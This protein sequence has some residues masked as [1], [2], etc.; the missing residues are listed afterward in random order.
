MNALIQDLQNQAYSTKCTRL[1]QEFI[2]L[3]GQPPCGEYYAEQAHT[4]KIYTCL[5]DIYACAHKIYTKVYPSDFDKF[6]RSFPKDQ[7]RLPPAVEYAQSAYRLMNF[8][9]L[10]IPKL[11]GMTFGDQKELYTD[12]RKKSEPENQIPPVFRMNM[13]I[14]VYL[15]ASK[16]LICGPLWK[17]FWTIFQFRC[18]KVFRFRTGQMIMS[19]NDDQLLKLIRVIQMEWKSIP[20]SLEFCTTFQVIEMAFAL[21]ISRVGDDS[22]YTI[23]CYRIESGEPGVYSFNETCIAMYSTILYGIKRR[24]CIY[25]TNLSR[26]TV[27]EYVSPESLRLSKL[28]MGVDPHSIGDGDDDDHGND[29][30]SCATESEKEGNKTNGGGVHRDTIID[31][32]PSKYE[33]QFLYERIKQGGTDVFGDSI[34]TTIRNFVQAYCIDPGSMEECILLCSGEYLSEKALVEKT[35]LL[36]E[37]SLLKEYMGLPLPKHIILDPRLYPM[38]MPACAIAVLDL[39]WDSCFPSTKIAN[40]LLYTNPH[41]VFENIDNIMKNRDPCLVCFWNEFNVVY[42]GTIY[43]T[44]NFLVALGLLLNIILFSG[45]LDSQRTGMR[46]APFFFRWYGDELFGSMVRYLKSPPPPRPSKN[47]DHTS[48]RDCDDDDDDEDPTLVV[49]KKR[50]RDHTSSSKAPKHGYTTAIHQKL[51][52]KHLEKMLNTS[53]TPQ[54]TIVPISS[55]SQRKSSSIKPEIIL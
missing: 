10:G 7:E 52:R 6:A 3:I 1:L 41:E 33:L 8:V 31:L 19:M 5:N 17:D 36:E 50:H 23:P 51:I 25:E 11:S 39:V 49:S 44:C 20:F 16:F 40:F 24:V 4:L 15:C 9:L 18:P 43:R 13:A 14:C 35:K 26:G 37:Q 27:V 22:V 30:S 32:W 38:S 46:L 12:E 42:Q 54:N 2:I 21:L 48:S 34:G 28:S 53:G 29:S 47:V 45:S 55:K